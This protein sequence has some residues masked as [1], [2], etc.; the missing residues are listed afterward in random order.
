MNRMEVPQDYN[1][2]DSF[3]QNKLLQSIGINNSHA[4]ATTDDT[5]NLQ[6][7]L[8]TKESLLNEHMLDE[9]VFDYKNARIN[10]EDLEESLEELSNSKYLH[11][12]LLHRPPNYLNTSS[13]PSPVSGAKQEK[14][15]SKVGQKA[16]RVNK[17][18]QGIADDLQSV[19]ADSSDKVSTPT[20]PS[21]VI[22]QISLILLCNFTA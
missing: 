5:M 21:S 11:E 18:N 2:N 14:Y 15:R 1:T 4:N 17:E 16:S 12:S 9:E 7:L 10:E 8:R 19:F 6:N 13:K 20:P 3:Y 22:E